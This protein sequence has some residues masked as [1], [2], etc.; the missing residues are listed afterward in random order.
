MLAPTTTRPAD[1]HAALAT[2]Q[3]RKMAASPHAFVRGSTPSFYQW[4]DPAS[5][6][7]GPPV[8]ICGDCHVGNLGPIASPTGALAIQI[9]DLDQTTIGNPAH[10]L[11]RLA[12]SLATAAR[13]SAL[14]GLV[15]ARM[16]EHLVQG[17]ETA[18]S[19]AAQDE[20]IDALQ[21]MPIPIRRV[22]RAAGRRSWRHLVV[23]RIRGTQRHI[24]L[25]KRFWPLTPEERTAIDDLFAQPDIRRLAT[26]LRSRPDDAPVRVLDAA[27]WRKGCSSL[28]NIRIAVLLVIGKGRE[29]RHCLMDIKQATAPAAPQHPKL[30]NVLHRAAQPIPADPAERVLA[31]ARALSPFLGQRM[32]ATHLLGHPVFIRELLPQDLKLEIETLTVDEAIGVSSFLAH[33]IGRAHARQ[34]DDAT[35]A[36]WVAELHRNRPATLDAPTWL[37]RSLIDLIA[38][39]ERAYLDYCRT[40]AH[41]EPA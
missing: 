23:E 20:S 24:P 32:V 14:P 19:P 3:R 37:W 39:H 4:L 22:M 38:A 36:E 5:I 15:T 18:F 28:G 2:E 16:L 25:G 34:M 17:Y 9:R 29:A 35:R 26:L 10:D 11:I 30:E 6:P 33:V 12:L 8:W 13:N 31:G 41:P 40:Y 21:D 27:Y 1:R 7:A